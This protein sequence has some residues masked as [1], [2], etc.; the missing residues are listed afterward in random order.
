MPT[1]HWFLTICEFCERPTPRWDMC[2]RCAKAYEAAR[3][4][5]DGTVHAILV[6][7]AKRARFFAKKRFF[8]EQRLRARK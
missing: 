4:K 1:D 3:R 5:D 2:E 8:A 7:A 6:W